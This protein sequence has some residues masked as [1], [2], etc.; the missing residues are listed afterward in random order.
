[1]LRQSLGNL[2]PNSRDTDGKSSSIIIIAMRARRWLRT[3]A[4]I[5]KQAFRKK[6]FARGLADHVPHPWGAWPLLR[7]VSLALKFEAGFRWCIRPRLMPMP[8][9]CIRSSTRTADFYW[10]YYPHL[11][12]SS[13]SNTIIVLIIDYDCT[14][15][16]I[17]I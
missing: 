12:C 2:R 6:G 16:K 7:R 9:I 17:N 4:C 1:M 3:R 15:R 13:V 8:C 11:H 10:N 14:R 5:T